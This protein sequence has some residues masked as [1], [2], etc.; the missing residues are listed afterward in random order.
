M[1]TCGQCGG[2]DLRTKRDN[3]GAYGMNTLPIGKGKKSTVAM[4]NTVCISCGHVEFRVGSPEA[5]AKI[6]ETWDP[7]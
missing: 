5:L 3:S 2:A 7:A 1:A 6:A 4:D